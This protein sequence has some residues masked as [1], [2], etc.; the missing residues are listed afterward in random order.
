M[1]IMCCFGPSKLVRNSNSTA[2]STQEFDSPKNV[3]ENDE[4]FRHTKAAAF[5]AAEDMFQANYGTR[6]ED[7]YGTKRIVGHGSFGQVVECMHKVSLGNSFL[8]VLEL[9]WV[10]FH[11]S[12]IASKGD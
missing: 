6:F 5:M 2:G 11:Q 3:N 10:T 12:W 4:D 9:S 7:R 1:V 8:K